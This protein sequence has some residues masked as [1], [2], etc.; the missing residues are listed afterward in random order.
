MVV[1]DFVK[2][3]PRRV[4]RYPGLRAP[5]GQGARALPLRGLSFLLL[6]MLARK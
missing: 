6:E 5:E 4:S 2:V 1:V 3:R